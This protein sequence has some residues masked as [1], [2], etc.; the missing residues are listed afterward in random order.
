[1]SQALTLHT[2]PLPEPLPAP[3]SPV[4]QP[5][6]GRL[7]LPDTVLYL[8]LQSWYPNPAL[9]GPPCSFRERHQLSARRQRREELLPSPYEWPLQWLWDIWSVQRFRRSFPENPPYP[10]H[11]HIFLF[12]VPF[13]QHRSGGPCFPP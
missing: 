2:P 3:E 10:D 1:M 12:P 8:P 5:L 9:S 4:S 7:R 13:P 6:R 11:L